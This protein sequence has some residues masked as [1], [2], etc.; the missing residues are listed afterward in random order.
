MGHPI[1]LTTPHLTYNG[2]NYPWLRKAYS[3]S[4]R[5]KVTMMPA[6]VTL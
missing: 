2:L 6:L 3:D 4:P 1:S 5:P